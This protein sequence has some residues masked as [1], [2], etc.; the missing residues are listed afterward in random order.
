MVTT[1]W[2]SKFDKS[3]DAYLIRKEVFIKEQNIPEELEV[4]SLDESAHHL[5]VYENDTPVATGR[6]IIKDGKY[7][8]GRIAVLKEHRGKHF[9]DLVVR[10]LV[11]KAFDLGAKEVHLHAQT[12]V[13]EFYEK[14]GFKAY[15]ETF[16]D[17]GIEHISMVIKEDVHGHCCKQ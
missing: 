7:Y 9:G 17:A 4:D 15:G 2:L 1:K 14:I 16:L 3:S 11:R 13:K 8:A 6:L 12:R 10:M 5:V